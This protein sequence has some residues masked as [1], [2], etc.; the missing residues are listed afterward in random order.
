MAELKS[1]LT[2]K[3]EITNTIK[4]IGVP[5]LFN[6]RSYINSYN[7]I[8]KQMPET[9]TPADVGWATFN[10]SLKDTLLNYA[11]D[12]FS[13]NFEF[14]IDPTE[15]EKTIEFFKSHQQ[16]NQQTTPELEKHINLLATNYIK[17][18]LMFRFM[19]DYWKIVVDDE[20]VTTSLHKFYQKTNQSIKKYLNDKN[21]FE[22]IRFQLINQTI[23]DKILTLYDFRFSL[24]FTPLQQ[25][26]EPVKNS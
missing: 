5:A 6:E 15:L 13:Q 9:A 2:L 4:E 20:K 25:N 14:N 19:I 12:N 22:K 23:T 18:E 10:V 3:H 11:L 24:K 8:Q 26:E 21:E 7:A 1:T 17:K 16:P